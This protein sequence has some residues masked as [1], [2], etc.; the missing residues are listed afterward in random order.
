M[1]TGLL[2]AILLVSATVA[3]GEE[4]KFKAQLSSMLNM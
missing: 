2:L 4:S 1:R 3:L